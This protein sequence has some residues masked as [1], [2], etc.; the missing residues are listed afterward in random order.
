M[1][2]D[3]TV[4]EDMRALEKEMARDQKFVDLLTERIRNTHDVTLLSQ[5]ATEMRNYAKNYLKIHFITPEAPWNED[6]IYPFSLRLQNTGEMNLTNLLFEIA[7]VRSP[8][9]KFYGDIRYISGFDTYGWANYLRVR[10]PYNLPAHDTVLWSGFEFKAIVDT[11]GDEEKILH[12]YLR[13]FDL[14]FNHLLGDDNLQK[15]N[16]VFAHAELEIVDL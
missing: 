5:L 6:E 11:D 7:P 4:L 13:D 8:E 14:N 12:T 3:K 10:C 9:S 1:T 15:E 2:H 16:G